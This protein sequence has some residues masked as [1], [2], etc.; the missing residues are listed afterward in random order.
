M[1]PT[2]IGGG[3][4]LVENFGKLYDRIRD[5]HD[6]NETVSIHLIET[7]LDHRHGGSSKL[8]NKWI[9]ELWSR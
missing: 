8:N 6:E 5:P 4:N 1:N 2:N 9:D 3:L 7:V